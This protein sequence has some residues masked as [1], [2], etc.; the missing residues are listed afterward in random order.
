MDNPY[1]SS[2]ALSRNAVTNDSARTNSTPSWLGF[3]V[4]MLVAPIALILAMYSG[5]GGHGGY[6]F[7][8]ALFPIP[9][10]VTRISDDTISI[11][12]IALAIIQFPAY[13]IVIGKSLRHGMKRAIFPFA[14]L[15]L[16]HGIATVFAFTGSL[17]NFSR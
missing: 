7:A 4:G 3:G 10:L 12:S 8:R 11:P 6:E 15:M 1:E 5:G 16:I 2:E 17:P 9:M 13:G 14:L